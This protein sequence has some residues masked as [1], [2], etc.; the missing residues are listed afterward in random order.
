[1]FGIALVLSSRLPR[2]RLDAE[3]PLVGGA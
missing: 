3:D 2:V 1:V